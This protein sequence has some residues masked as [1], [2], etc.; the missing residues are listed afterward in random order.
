MK[1]LGLISILWHCGFALDRRNRSRLDGR[2][3][4]DGGK[5]MLGVIRKL[6]TNP[7]SISL[8]DAAKAF[9]VEA[10][11][12]ASSPRE[13]EILAT[14]A[15]LNHLTL[16]NPELFSEPLGGIRNGGAAF[17]GINPR[18]GRRRTGDSMPEALP[19]PRRVCGW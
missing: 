7:S 10:E 6:K 9:R 12:M 3:G 2:I 4:S 17:S 11:A 13:A 19:G 14:A 15:L 8:E 16:T 1:M 18:P 5:T